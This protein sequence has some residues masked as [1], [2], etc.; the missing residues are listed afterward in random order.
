MD[1]LKAGYALDMLHQLKQKGLTKFIG[2]SLEAQPEEAL[3][4]MEHGIDVL[5]IRFNLLFPEAIKVFPTVAKKEIG[6]IINSPFAHGYLSGRYRTYEDIADGDYPKG[7]FRA[8][9]PPELVEAMIRRANAFSELTRQSGLS[10][11]SAALKYTLTYKDVSS[12]IPGHR[13]ETELDENV[14]TSGAGPFLGEETKLAEQVY[15]RV[16]LGLTR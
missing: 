2:V 10:L 4:A 12:V 8:T 7:P 6:L 3:I 16:V 9:K 1:V 15:H 14:A 5:Q 11:S 13:T